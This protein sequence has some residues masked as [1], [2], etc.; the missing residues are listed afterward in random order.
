M[1]RAF[2]HPKNNLRKQL[3][4]LKFDYLAK[5]E[6]KDRIPSEFSN[7]KTEVKTNYD[8][9]LYALFGNILNQTPQLH[10]LGD[11]AI[12]TLGEYQHK[13]FGGE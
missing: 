9:S 12:C 1:R 4:L 5:G 3:Q 7:Q 13:L 11:E 2:F 8:S 10:W 6:Y